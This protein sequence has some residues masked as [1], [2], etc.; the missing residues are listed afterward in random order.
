MAILSD[1]PGFLDRIN[2][3][4]DSAD[5]DVAEARDAKPV[6]PVSAA[7]AAVE[8]MALTCRRSHLC[9]QMS[10]INW[11]CCC[12]KTQPSRRQLK[13]KT[14][15]PPAARAFQS[16]L[17]S[18]RVMGPWVLT[19]VLNRQGRT[20]RAT[21]WALISLPLHKWTLHVICSASMSCAFCVACTGLFPKWRIDGRTRRHRSGPCS[22]SFG[23]AMPRCVYSRR[24]PFC[25]SGD[26]VINQRLSLEW[27][28]SIVARI[29]ASGIDVSLF[30]AVGRGSV[31]SSL[32]RGAESSAYY[33][34]RVE[35]LVVETAQLASFVAPTFGTAAGSQFQTAACVGQLQAAV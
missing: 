2:I 1:G 33:D 12:P 9:P 15:T 32:V 34:R 18:K 30:E 31:V 21:L 29:A 25:P 17:W 4:F 13:P 22:G 23:A 6:D 5:Q 26:L 14:L 7:I 19:W 10:P 16:T 3:T 28:Q 27:A 24:G 35:F 20:P 8:P 11:P